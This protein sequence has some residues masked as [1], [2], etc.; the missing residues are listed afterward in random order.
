MERG[1]RREEKCFDNNERYN[2]MR[3]KLEVTLDG[4]KVLKQSVQSYIPYQ[5]THE[6]FLLL[7]STLFYSLFDLCFYSFL[8]FIN[9]FNRTMVHTSDTK[10]LNIAATSM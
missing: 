6:V 2:A 1:E 7:S 4:L 8:V 10:R 3:S 9:I 5:K